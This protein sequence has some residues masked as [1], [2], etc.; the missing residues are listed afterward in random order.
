MRVLSL[1]NNYCNGREKD[2]VPVPKKGKQ[3]NALLSW[4]RVDRGRFINRGIKLQSRRKNTFG[5]VSSLPETASRSSK[6]NV[7]ERGKG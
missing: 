6:T 7:T 2:K 1:S 4:S 3:K 5:I